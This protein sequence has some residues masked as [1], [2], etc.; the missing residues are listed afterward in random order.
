MAG[1]MGA[2]RSTQ[3][4]LVVHEID[5]ERN[6]ILVRG[7]IPGPNQGIVEIREEGR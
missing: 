3:R 5:P 6:L 7:A 2:R 4:G 1:H